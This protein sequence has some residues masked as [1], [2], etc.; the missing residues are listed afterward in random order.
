MSHFTISCSSVVESSGGVTN[1]G[2]GGVSVGPG[3]H[4]VTLLGGIVLSYY[5]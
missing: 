2:G 4:L 3:L 1:N 5:D